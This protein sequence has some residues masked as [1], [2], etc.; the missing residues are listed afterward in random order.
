MQYLFGEKFIKPY[1]YFYGIFVLLGAVG[2]IDVVWNFVDMVISFM[3][4]P[5]LIA[6]LML[7]PIVKKEIDA[8]FNEMKMNNKP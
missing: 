7:T 8:Y 5:N 2:S 1:Y 6:M 3:T 4:I